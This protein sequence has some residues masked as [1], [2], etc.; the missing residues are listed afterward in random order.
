M[1]TTFNIS[2]SKE[3]KEKIQK[4]TKEGGFIS[5]SEFIRATVRFYLENKRFFGKKK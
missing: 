2:I 4:M 1:R 5:V 3:L